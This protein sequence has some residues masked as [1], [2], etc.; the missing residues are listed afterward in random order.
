MAK[1]TVR[2]V[3]AAELDRADRI[4]WDDELPGLGLRVKPSG[5]KSFVLQYRDARSRSRRL[6]IA[7]CGI[8]TPDDARKEAR[9]LLAD[10]ARGGALSVS[11]ARCGRRPLSLRSGP[12]ISRSTRRPTT[13]LRRSPNSAALSRSSSYRDSA[14]SASPLSPVT[15][16]Q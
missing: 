7:R 13:S 6:T 12:A 1:V 9:H 10:V 14:H 8:M 11:G 2:T 3:K 4:L 5:A 16:S 15:I